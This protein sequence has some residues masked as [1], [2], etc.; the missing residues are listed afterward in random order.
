MKRAISL[1]FLIAC[2][3]GPAH[4]PQASSLPQSLIDKRNLYLNLTKAEQGYAGFT[5]LDNC[6]SVLYSGLLGA[7]GAVVDLTAARL[8]D[9]TWTRNPTRDCY[10]DGGSDSTFSRDMFMGLLWWT[11]ENS[12]L[13]VAQAT[14]DYCALQPTFT[15]TGC[16]FG[17]GSLFDPKYIITQNGLATLTRL[18]TTLGGSDH[19][20]I[21]NL[22]TKESSGLVG[23]EANLAVLHIL[24][25]GRLENS[26]SDLNLAVLKEQADRQPQNALFQFAYHKYTDG[27]QTS[28]IAVLENEQYFPADRLPTSADRCEEYLWQRDYGKDW[29]PCDDGKTHPGADFLFLTQQLME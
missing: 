27:D 18:I 2:G 10:A 23:F 4:P 5:D 12:R 22:Y 9:G 7:G 20:V 11:F 1:L 24:L 14:Y 16:I 29:I 13:D 17:Q 28:A 21:D 3:H 15:V 8:A 6:D 25:R 26:V 19:P